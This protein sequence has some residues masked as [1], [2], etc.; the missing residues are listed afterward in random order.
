MPYVAYQPE[1]DDIHFV[2]QATPE[3]DYVCIDCPESVEYV[4]SHL[5]NSGSGDS[6][7]VSAHFRYSNCAHGTVDEVSDGTGGGGGGGGAGETQL[8][9]RRKRAALHEALQRFPA[10]DYGTEYSVGSKRADALL[11]FEDPHEE[12]G[13]GL[14]IEYQH[15][16]EG[17]D[18]E[19]TQEHFARH[20]YTTVWLWEDQFTF[21]S[22]IPDIDLFGGEVY[23]PWPDAVKEQSQWTGEGLV[24]IGRRQGGTKASAVMRQSTSDRHLFREHHP[25]QT[26][27]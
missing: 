21:S 23:T 17:K 1:S 2:E 15:K 8:H 7:R 26:I 14:V 13:K 27:R 16:N 10:A 11:E 12:Y 24:S 4:R 5:R 25:R 3:D 20:E 19:A 22:S 18:I 9:K 6:T